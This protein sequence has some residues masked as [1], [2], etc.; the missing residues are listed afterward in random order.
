[1]DLTTKILSLAFFLIGIAASGQLAL[2]KASLTSN[3]RENLTDDIKAPRTDLLRTGAKDY[4]FGPATRIKFKIIEEGS[5]LSTTYFKIA[6][7]PY[8]KSDGRQMVPH[9]LADGSYAIAYYSE[10]KSGNQE[11][12]RMDE[13]YID[14]KGPQIGTAFNSSPISYENGLPVFSNKVHLLVEVA[15]DQVAVQKLTYSINDGPIVNSSNTELL[16]LSEELLSI[17]GGLV[18]I[19]IRAYDTFYNLSKEVVEFSIKK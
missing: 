16:D 11:Q 9:D 4:I 5:G 17:T 19:E 10:D 18:K 2:D 13:I 1:M 6:D 3:E 15:D 7:L 12:I 8:M 14:K